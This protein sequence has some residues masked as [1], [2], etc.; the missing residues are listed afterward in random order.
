MSAWWLALVAL[1]FVV[2][3]AGKSWELAFSYLGL[4]IGLSISLICLTFAW[5]I[6]RHPR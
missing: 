6:W 1:L 2:V 5:K 4:A 3:G